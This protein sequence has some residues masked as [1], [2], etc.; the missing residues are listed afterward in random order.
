MFIPLYFCLRYSNLLSYFDLISRN[1]D[2]YSL[3]KFSLDISNFTARIGL[4]SD[5]WLLILVFFLIIERYSHITQNVLLFYLLF[6]E[7]MQLLHE[8]IRR[9]IYL[10]RN[11]CAFHDQLVRLLVFFYRVKDKSCKKDQ[12]T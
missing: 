5:F 3:K 12:Q 9:K 1:F 2:S 6:E 10:S 8:H 7:L 4:A 11:F